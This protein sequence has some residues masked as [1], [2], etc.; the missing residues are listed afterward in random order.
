MSRADQTATRMLIDE[1]SRTSLKSSVRRPI[2]QGLSRRLYRSTVSEGIAGLEAGAVKEAR[3]CFLRAI[4]L[5]PGEFYAWKGLAASVLPPRVRNI[6][7][8]M[9][10][11]IRV[12]LRG[13]ADL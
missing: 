7:R 8:S 9:Q 6:A 10:R 5:L 12:Q 1:L 4:G 13:A 2:R 3:A 11:R